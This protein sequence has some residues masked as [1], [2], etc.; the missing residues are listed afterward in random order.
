MNNLLVILLGIIAVECAIPLIG[1]RLPDGN[2]WKLYATM[3][4]KKERMKMLLI[5]C[6]N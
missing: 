2:G 1:R 4:L 6:G 5:I 3:C